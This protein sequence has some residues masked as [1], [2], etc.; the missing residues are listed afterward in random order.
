MRRNEGFLLA[1]VLAVMVLVFLLTMSMSSLATTSLRVAENRRDRV[2]AEQ[3]AEAGLALA[4]AQIEATEEPPAEIS[5]T[6][7]DGVNCT[8]QATL[9]DTNELGT[10]YEVHAKGYGEKNAEREIAA[11]VYR[12]YGEPV[13]NPIFGQGLVSKDRVDVNGAMIMHGVIHGD[14][15]FSMDGMVN[16]LAG[17]ATA[18]CPSEEIPEDSCFCMTHP[19]RPEYCFMGKPRHVVP[20]ADI[21]DPSDHIEALWEKYKEPPPEDG[22]DTVIEGDLLITNSAQLAALGHRVRVINGNVMISSDLQ[23]ENIEFVLDDDR[24]LHVSGSADLSSVK[25][26]AGGIV[27][28][29]NADLDDVKLF[30]KNRVVF[31]GVIEPAH[32]VVIVADDVATNGFADFYDSKILVE[33]DYIA[34]GNMRFHGESTIV[35]KG[36]LVFNGYSVVEGNIEDDEA[37]KA[38]TVIAKGNIAFNGMGNPLVMVMWAGGNVVINDGASM[39]YGGVLAQGRIL[40][41]GASGIFARIVDNEDLPT[42]DTFDGVKVLSRTVV[43]GD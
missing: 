39:L 34:N 8:Y 30:A 12:S 7:G 2:V 16:F 22:F 40:K 26:W 5:G 27:I 13:V 32:D 20:P 17:G 41:N 37:V 31:N 35:S 24:V 10:L 29:S 43:F 14:H 1:T 19:P 42:V 6:C 4:M 9:K 18:S 11:L 36:N 38:P 3:A 33:K 25:I 23:A 28:D 21:G 15:G